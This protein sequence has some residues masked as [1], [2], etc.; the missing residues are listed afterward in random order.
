MYSD[1]PLAEIAEKSA[2]SSFMQSTWPIPMFSRIEN[3]FRKAKHEKR[4]EL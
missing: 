3:P 2:S 4:R 1:N